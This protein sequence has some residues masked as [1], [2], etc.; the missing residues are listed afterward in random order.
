MVPILKDLCGLQVLVLTF[1]CTLTDLVLKWC[2]RI[3]FL[4]F[5]VVA[6]CAIKTIENVK[7]F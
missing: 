6:A 3:R 7:L 1:F 2:A 5:S 4:F